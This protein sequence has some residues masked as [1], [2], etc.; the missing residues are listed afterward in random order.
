MGLRF[1]KSITI[2][3]GVRLT[4]GKR[5]GSISIG[6]RGHRATFSTT[7]R[8]T[9]TVGIP[10]TG[11]SYSVSSRKK[12]EE[13]K[14]NKEQ[15][16][17]EL[18]KARARKEQEKR[19]EL[20]HAQAV[21]EEFESK[22]DAVT[23]LHRNGAETIPWGSIIKEE[24]PFVYGEQGPNEMAARKEAECYKPNVLAKLIHR[25]NSAENGTLQAS[26]E[27]AQQKDLH[28]YNEW[29]YWHNMG[30]RLLTRDEDTIEAMLE[31]ISDTDIFDDLIEYG[32]G[33]EVGFANYLVAEVEFR[34]KSDSVIPKE[35]PS[36]TQG[37]KLSVKPMPVMR[38]MELIKQY[39]CSCSLR[40]ASDMFAALP[41]GAVIVHARDYVIDESTG[42]LREGDILSVLYTPDIINKIKYDS[43]QPSELIEELI[44]TMKF[45]KTKGFKNINRIIVD[46]V[47]DEKTGHEKLTV[48]YDS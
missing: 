41:I 34:V 27:K 48:S 12:H 1:R 30:Q 10:G 5:S 16:E 17:R 32:S 23:S 44:H 36:V 6:G 21:V 8:K 3:P 19:A 14:R 28:D 42:S 11:L 37:G 45:M 4:V 39:V 29:E 25:F 47:T 31:I 46:S 22:I 43:V 9:A 2:A 40:I 33:F 15:K 18:A 26:I 20:E 7:G 35:V 24:P 38:R 13:A